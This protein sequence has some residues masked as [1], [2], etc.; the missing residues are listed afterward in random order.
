[1]NQIKIQIKNHFHAQ[2]KLLIEMESMLVNALMK[3]KTE[4]RYDFSVLN[5]AKDYLECRLVQL[6]IFIHDANNKLI[7]EVADLTG[8]FNRMFNE[9]HLK[10]S[11]AGLVLEVL[12][13]PLILSKWNQTKNLMQQASDKNP[14]LK[15]LIS[16]SD[17]LFT[18]PEKILQ[19]IQANEFIQV[20]FGN[21]FDTP[22]PFNKQEYNRTNYLN[23][24][25]LPFKITAAE[26]DGDR[27]E[28][29]AK[30]QTKSTPLVTLDKDFKKN[31][32]KSFEDKID[33][34]QLNPN[35]EETANHFVET[36]SGKLIKAE[37]LKTEFVED[38]LYTK[39]N[40]KMEIEG[41]FSTSQEPISEFSSQDST[42]SR[43]S[44]F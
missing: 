7:N 2:Y 41:S 4:I 3:S 16:L 21:I 9:L 35:I 28:G 15:E 31:A 34:K 20:Y 43:F 1:M 11:Y 40:Y 38:R 32:Y 24:A 22:I 23:T 33:L 10:M 26:S 19:A 14:D 29:I 25:Y 13:M 39:M 42:Q 36:N 8:A 6:D 17:N 5:I 44:F 27:K 37:V 12:N 30:I 18:S